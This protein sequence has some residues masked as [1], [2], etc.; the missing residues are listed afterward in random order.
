MLSGH[1]SRH[2]FASKPCTARVGQL[3]VGTLV[4]TPLLKTTCRFSQSHSGFLP[5]PHLQAKARVLPFVLK[6]KKDHTMFFCFVQKTK[7]IPLKQEP[8]CQCRTQ[9]SLCG[10][11]V[12]KSLNKGCHPCHHRILPAVQG[13]ASS[14]RPNWTRTPQDFQADQL[15][16]RI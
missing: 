16:C 15:K 9:C 4:L 10:W 3:M 12:L 13:K 6:I 11:L 8:K 1:V 5:S 2:S 14:S 7:T